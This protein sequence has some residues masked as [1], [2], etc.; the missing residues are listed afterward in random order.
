MQFSSTLAAAALFLAAASPALAE[1][2]RVVTN[3]VAVSEEEISIDTHYS[4]KVFSAAY[5]QCLESEAHAMYKEALDIY[6]RVKKLM[7][8]TLCKEGTVREERL[9][10]IVFSIQRAENILQTALIVNKREGNEL[11]Q[12]W[13]RIEIKSLL[14]RLAVAQIKATH[15]PNLA[16]A[17]HAYKFVV[18]ETKLVVGATVEVALAVPG[19]IVG[20]TVAVVK[21]AILTIKEAAKIVKHCLHEIKVKIGWV[22]DEVEEEFIYIGEKIHQIGHD[23]KVGL[24][25]IG[26][27][28]KVGIHEKWDHLKEKFHRHSCHDDDS[29][30]P[31]GPNDDHCSIQTGEVVLVQEEE[32]IVSIS[33]TKKRAQLKVVEFVQECVDEEVELKDACHDQEASVLAAFGVEGGVEVGDGSFKAGIGAGAGVGAE[34]GNGAV[35]A[36]VGAGAGAGIEIG[37]GGIKAGFGLGGGAGVRIGRE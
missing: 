29:C 27:D 15:L 6:Y 7:L 14:D 3:S 36:G 13:V 37:H 17:E 28:I 30:T 19:I 2:P 4:R 22:I 25:D 23:I 11:R 5:N 9:L 35:G 26:H 20:A 16:F 24:H 33:I 12:K 8:H 31:C 10:D 34:A 32:Q 18:D 1:G 21:G